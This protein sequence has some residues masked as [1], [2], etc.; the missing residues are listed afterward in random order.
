MMGTSQ[1]LRWAM[2]WS[3]PKM[4]TAASTVRKRPTRTLSTPKVVFRE[5]AMVLDCTELKQS[6]KV[7][8][9]S[10]AKRAAALRL[11]RQLRI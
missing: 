7:K 8:E 11:P 3:P 6:P 4:T 9:M 10:T 1:L 2:R 5:M